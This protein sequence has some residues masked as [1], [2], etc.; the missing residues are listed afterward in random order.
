MKIAP[1]FCSVYVITKGKILSTQ[2]AQRTP[3]YN[4]PQKT[5]S[6][7]VIPSQSL[8]DNA[9]LDLDGVR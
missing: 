7:P 8:Q 6:M 4:V 2:K 9:E 3:T 1:D 5:A